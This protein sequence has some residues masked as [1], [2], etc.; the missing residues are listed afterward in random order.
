[1]S[2]ALSFCY[3]R[4]SRSRLRLWG[5][6]WMISWRTCLIRRRITFAR[7]SITTSLTDSMEMRMKSS[8]KMESRTRMK[9][10]RP[11]E[12]SCKTKSTGNWTNLL[13]KISLKAT[14]KS[15][16]AKNFYWKT[17]HSSA[18]TQYGS[19]SWQGQS[20]TKHPRDW[21]TW[22][23]R[24]T[25]HAGSTISSQA[26][27]TRQFSSLSWTVFSTGRSEFMWCVVHY[28]LILLHSILAQ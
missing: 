3:F 17:M 27:A 20:W 21:T 15:R 10:N 5:R 13:R 8:A 12:K 25:D 14:W 24:S 6:S 11:M 23:H 26:E 19:K 28:I 18:Q 16:T 7:S 4:P 1:M 2:T 9:K 22:Q